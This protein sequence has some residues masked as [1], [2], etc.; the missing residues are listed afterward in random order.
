MS[1]AAS[2]LPRYTPAQLE[3]HN[4]LKEIRA[5]QKAAMVARLQAE[6]DR[7]RA[8]AEA[9]RRAEMARLE[10]I[11]RLEEYKE[12]LA[13]RRIAAARS[14]TAARMPETRRPHCHGLTVAK[15]AFDD[16]LARVSE[17]YGIPED[18]IL[19]PNR[20]SP[21]VAARTHLMVILAKENPYSSL[22]SLG[23]AVGRDHTTILHGL[24]RWNAATG[25]NVRMCGS[26]AKSNSPLEFKPVRARAEKRA[27]AA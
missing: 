3:A 2:F 13:E 15:T 22:P 17:A 7:Q 14:L 27:M 11:R 5:R 4:R 18:I 6:A 19:S 25:E 26:N 1:A 23:R 20:M 24:R 21:V 12:A 16:A 8:I 9:A 10:E